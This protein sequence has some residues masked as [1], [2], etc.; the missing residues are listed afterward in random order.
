MKFFIVI[1]FY[2]SKTTFETTQMCDSEIQESFSFLLKNLPT[3]IDKEFVHIEEFH[4][5]DG[6]SIALNLIKK[7]M[8]QLMVFSF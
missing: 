6:Y 5:T 8:H 4:V 3:I 2:Y 1:K 7:S